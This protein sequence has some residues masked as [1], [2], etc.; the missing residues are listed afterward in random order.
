MPELAVLPA[1]LVVDLD[2]TAVDTL[3]DLEVGTD[4]RVD[5]RELLL[6]DLVE[7]F[8]GLRHDRGIV[9]QHPQRRDLAREP[10]L[11]RILADE[12]RLAVGGGGAIAV[13]VVAE[14]PADRDHHIFLPDDQRAGRR[15]GGFVHA[16][17]HHIGADLL[18][19]VADDGETPGVVDDVRNIVGPG[20]LGDPLLQQRGA[21]GVLLAVA[22]SRRVVSQGGKASQ[23]RFMLFCGLAEAV[24]WSSWD[25]R[26]SSTAPDDT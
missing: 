5:L 20:D 7:V 17:D 23:E 15:A 6:H 21:V 22:V 25:R 18:D 16:V 9:A 2:R 4:P 3:V 26:S 19:A 1:V 10:F 12:R 24:R 11:A 13:P 14:G 8:D